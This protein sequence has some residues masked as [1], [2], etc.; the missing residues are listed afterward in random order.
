MKKNLAEKTNSHFR[1][2]IQP[3]KNSQLLEKKCKIYNK[4][5]KL[6]VFESQKQSA[7]LV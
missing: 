6:E 1:Q 7:K 4:I 3:P 5:I 2:T